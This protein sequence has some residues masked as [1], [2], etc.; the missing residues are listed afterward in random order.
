MNTTTI[1]TPDGPMVVPVL[2]ERRGLAVTLVP[3]TTGGH[4]YT[5]THL[6]SGRMVGWGGVGVSTLRQALAMLSVAEAAPIDWLAD[7][8]DVRVYIA[9]MCYDTEDLCY[10]MERAR[11]RGRDLPRQIR[12]RRSLRL[13]V[14]AGVTK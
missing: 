14:R 6:E 13:R 4:A 11:L 7:W 5:V 9:M 8:P 1:Q 2:A 12:R 3:T 10:R